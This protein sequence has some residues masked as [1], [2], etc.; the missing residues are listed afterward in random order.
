MTMFE[1]LMGSL[2][3]LYSLTRDSVSPLFSNWVEPVFLPSCHSFLVVTVA[4]F[5]ENLNVLEECFKWFQFM[6]LI[7]KL[8]M[9][10]MA[11]ASMMLLS[12]I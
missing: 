6:V 8:G 1:Y 11:H 12:F 3:P 4:V 2:S 5:Y 9:K 7:L 10:E